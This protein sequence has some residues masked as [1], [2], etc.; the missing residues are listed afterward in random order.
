MKVSSGRRASRMGDQIMRE[1][2]NMLLEE[3]QDPRLA[4]VTLS[5][6]RMNSNLRV[7]EV[8]YTLSGGEEN[9]KDAEAALQKAKGFLRSG[10]GR[11]L[12]LRYLPELRFVYDSFLEDMIYGK[13]CP[14]NSPD[15]KG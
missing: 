8:L 5:G 13:P 3:S 2:A 6:V 10:L 7:A 1:L 11:R 15:N 12:K 9:L 4:K 14:E